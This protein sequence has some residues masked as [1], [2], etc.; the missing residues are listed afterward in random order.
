M[1][2][3]NHRCFVVYEPCIIAHTLQD[4]EEINWE[5]VARDAAAAIPVTSFP[6]RVLEVARVV[7]SKT[8]EQ[9]SAQLQVDRDDVAAAS[10]KIT[11]SDNLTDDEDYVAGP[12]RD[13]VKLFEMRMQLGRKDR[14]PRSY[15]NVTMEGTT[16]YRVAE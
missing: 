16:S 1:S 10:M 6:R 9:Y 11:L 13:A 12:V 7:N 15:K 3:A 4:V 5:D 14:A 2:E 8:K